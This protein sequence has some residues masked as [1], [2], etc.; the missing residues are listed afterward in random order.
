MGI[1]EGKVPHIFYS[2]CTSLSFLLVQ[3]SSVKSSLLLV[4][5]TLSGQQTKRSMLFKVRVLG[6]K[7]AKE[8]SFPKKCSYRKEPMHACRKSGKSGTLTS[9]FTRST[10]LCKCLTFTVSGQIEGSKVAKVMG[11]NGCVVKSCISTHSNLKLSFEFSNPFK[12]LTNCSHQ[13]SND[14]QFPR[15]FNLN[16][17]SSK[18][19]SLVSIR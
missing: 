18:N 8:G 15:H 16:M 3:P 1:I 7:A 12:Q 4:L 6:S 14:A 9:H 10:F 2:V 11:I 5:R 17:I 13:H 19:G